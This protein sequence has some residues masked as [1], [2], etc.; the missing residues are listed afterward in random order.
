MITTHEVQSLKGNL[1]HIRIVNII[2][3]YDH[4]FSTLIKAAIE[5]EFLDG[6]LKGERSESVIEI[7]D[8]TTTE[9]TGD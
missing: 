8:V 6:P 5:I 4:S 2:D 7:T 9:N 1:F 3:V